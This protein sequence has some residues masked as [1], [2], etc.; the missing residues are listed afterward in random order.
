MSVSL[1]ISSF[2]VGPFSFVQTEQYQ[3]CANSKIVP[4]V[5]VCI[6]VTCSHCP[7]TYVCVANMASNA[8]SS[9]LILVINDNM[10]NETNHIAKHVFVDIPR[11]Q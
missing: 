4:S 5:L 7:K 11:S 9:S 3:Q 10:T 1:I 2:H 6:H 8:I